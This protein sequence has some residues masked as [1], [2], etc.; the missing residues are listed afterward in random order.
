M[1]FKYSAI[2]QGG[3]GPDV[4]ETTANVEGENMTISEALRSITYDL[5][6]EYEVIKIEREE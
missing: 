5:P 4:W 3:T 1:I 2:L 6:S